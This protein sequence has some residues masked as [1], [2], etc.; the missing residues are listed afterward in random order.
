[1]T[2]A[3]L[4]LVTVFAVWLD[5]VFTMEIVEKITPIEVKMSS[6]RPGYPASN[7]IDGNKTTM[8][9]TRGSESY[10]WITL[11]IPRSLVRQIDIKYRRG[12]KRLKYVKMWV[13][14]D[15]PTTTDE[16]YTGGALFRAIPGW[17]LSGAGF[18]GISISSD[19]KLVGTHVVLQTKTDFLNLTEIEVFTEPASDKEVDGGWSTW[20]YGGC[21]KT[22]GGGTQRGTRSCNN[23]PPSNGGKNCVGSGV[24]NTQCNTKPCPG[25]GGWS[26]WSYGGCSKTCGGGTQRGTR[27]CNNP[28]PSNGGKNCVGSGVTNTQCN[29][30]PCSDDCYCGLAKRKLTTTIVGGQETG[31]N[32]YPWQVLL[33]YWG[34]FICGGSLISDQWVL[35]AAHCVNEGTKES[36]VKVFL[37]EHDKEDTNEA[38]SLEMDV[39]EIILHPQMIITWRVVRN[40]FAL[41]KLKSKINFRSHPHIRPIC[42]PAPSN[43]DYSGYEATATGWGRISFGGFSHPHLLEADLTVVSKTMCESRFPWIIDNE[44]LCTKSTSGKGICKG[45]SGGPLITKE[46]G[47]SGTVPGQNYELIGVTSFTPGRRCRNVLQGF[48]RVTTQLQWIRENTN[49]SWRTCPRT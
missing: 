31:V 15:F 37:G 21:S 35:T 8:C 45:D 17:W 5:F 40:D 11:V 6:L 18:S 38:D 1:M 46:A 14:E 41:L 39:V 47:Y 32:E 13:G 25:D 28:P 7:C 49:D 19:K 26:T 9:Q 30:Q 12:G 20:S 3:F 48:A 10:P 2:P 34:V 27:S 29:T 16:E 4:L 23:P 36:D 42:L 33:T 22:C 43:N 24:T 44:V